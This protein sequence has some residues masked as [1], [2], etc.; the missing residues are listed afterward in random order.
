LKRKF[1][2]SFSEELHVTALRRKFN[3]YSYS[4]WRFGRDGGYV[5]WFC[6]AA[7]CNTVVEGPRSAQSQVFLLA[8]NP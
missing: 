1:D 8:G 5:L 7:G 6:E 3:G 2:N 4:V